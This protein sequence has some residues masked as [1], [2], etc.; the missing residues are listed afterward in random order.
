MLALFICAGIAAAFVIGAVSG[1]RLGL[2]L[3]L[4]DSAPTTSTIPT[5]EGQEA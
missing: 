5:I 4:E 2:N 1:I 3:A